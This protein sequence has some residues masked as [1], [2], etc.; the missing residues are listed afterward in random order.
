V[1]ALVLRARTA[2]PEDSLPTGHAISL[3]PAAER[4]GA[5]LARRTASFAGHCL[6]AV[7]L[8]L[9]GAVAVTATL[10]LVLIAAPIAA[11]IV[12]WVVWRSGDLAA[13]EARRLRA[14]LRK[15]RALGLTVI[16]P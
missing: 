11:P 7:A 9:G 12:L 1:K 2:H 14:R 8:V 4:A 6:F 3:H 15:A 5:N 16:P 10:L 13:R